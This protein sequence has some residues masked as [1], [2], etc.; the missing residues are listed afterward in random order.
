M[1]S[2]RYAIPARHRFAPKHSH[3]I[4]ARALKKRSARAIRRT[5][6]PRESDDLPGPVPGEEVA[7]R[8]GCPAASAAEMKEL[9]YLPESYNSLSTCI[10]TPSTPCRTL[11]RPSRSLS[12]SFSLFH[13]VRQARLFLFFLVRCSPPFPSLSAL[14]KFL[15]PSSSLPHGGE[16]RLFPLLHFPRPSLARRYGYT[17]A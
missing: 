11:L 5:R 16:T 15:A 12:L 8:P 10:R 7:V 13:A 6:V 17:L 14:S 4:Y 9:I 3:S 2:G 1:D